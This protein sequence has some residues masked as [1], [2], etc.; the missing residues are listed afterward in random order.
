[1]RSLKCEGAP[2]RTEGSPGVGVTKLATRVRRGGWTLGLQVTL[3]LAKL[4]IVGTSSAG[5]S[6]TEQGTQEL[7]LHG[8]YFLARPV[9]YSC[10]ILWVQSSQSESPVDFKGKGVSVFLN[11]RVLKALSDGWN[12]FYSSA[13]LYEIL[14]LPLNQFPHLSLDGGHA[15]KYRLS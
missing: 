4:F 7:V 12:E 1:M 2:S 6:E 15:G 13:S 8:S 14:K 5:V 9:F 3:V 10:V 11:P